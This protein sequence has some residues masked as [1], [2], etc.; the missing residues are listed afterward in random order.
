MIGALVTLQPSSSWLF[1]CNSN[2]VRN[3]LWCISTTHNQIAIEFGTCHDGIA[4]VSCT[5]FCSDH[6]VIIKVRAK[7]N[8]HRI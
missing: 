1:A 8:Y 2:S 6:C 7:T 4:V 3:S 5:K